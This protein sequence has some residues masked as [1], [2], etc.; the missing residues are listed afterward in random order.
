[1]DQLVEQ[2]G[3]RT[4]S[5]GGHILC[6]Q[7][8]SG[9]PDFFLVA[10][11]KERGGIQLDENYVPKEIQEV[12]L[13]TVQQT[14]RINLGASSRSLPRRLYKLLTRPRMTKTKR[15]LIQPICVLLAVAGT[16]RPQTISFPLW[17]VPKAWRRAG[18]VGWSAMA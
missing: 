16:V 11:T 1:M 17:D 8:T 2:V 15:K 3:N 13:K 7:Y 12:D 5:T 10:S 9:A 14:A 4:L 18:P 6:A